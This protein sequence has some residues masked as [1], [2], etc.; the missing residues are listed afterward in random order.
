[1]LLCAYD[2]ETTGLDREKSL[3]TEIGLCLYSTE[4]NRILESAGFLVQPVGVPITPQITELTGITQSA[5]DR[6][7][8]SQ[9]D[10]VASFIDFAEKAD[11]IIG[12]NSNSFDLPIIQNSAKRACRVLP[13]KLSIDTMTDIPGVKGEQLITMCAKA[14]FVYE[15]HGALPDAMAVLKLA[16]FHAHRSIVTTY[17]RIMERAKSPLVVLQSHQSRQDNAAAKQAKFRWN[18]PLKGWYKIVKEIDIP[19]LEFSFR[20]SRADKDV[21]PVWD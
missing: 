1:M 7:G 20:V 12:H 17:E 15:A 16:A 18:D 2:I 3:I 8:Y 13:A 19:D 11:A 14:G 4:Q 6:F 5:V 21:F 9:E 10:A